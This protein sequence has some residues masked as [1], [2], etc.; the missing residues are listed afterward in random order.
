M[1]SQ[2][3]ERH[4]QQTILNCEYEYEDGRLSAIELTASIINKFPPQIL[5]E[6]AQLFFLPLVLRLVNDDS[7]KCK[8]AVS[9]A[10]ASLLKRSSIDTVQSL[11]EYIKRWSEAS[12]P[13]SIPMQKASAQLFGIFVDSRP[14]YIRGGS[15]GALLVESI[16]DMLQDKTLDWELA[17]YYLTC[18]E[19]IFNQ[20]QSL[21]PGSHHIWPMLVTLLKHPHPPMM[22][23]RPNRTLFA[24][25]KFPC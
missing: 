5:E 20:L 3:L 17:Y 23:V 14:D 21:L 12:G 22:Q 7:Q 25:F 2:R 8:D 10:I 6:R 16:A 24:S 11:Y 13:D 4:L 15:T 1:G 9:D 19:K 18:V